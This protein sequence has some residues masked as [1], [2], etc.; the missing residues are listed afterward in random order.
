METVAGMPGLK[1]I[2]RHI[3][4]QTLAAIDIPATMQDKLERSGSRIVSDTPGLDVD[5]DL[6]DYHNIFAV[7][8]GKASLSMARG[9]VEL[10]GPGVCRQ[11]IM[12]APGDALGEVP[13]FRAIAAGHPLPDSGSVRAAREILDLLS[14]CDERSLVFFLLSGGGS[15]LMELP[16]D[17]AV[18]LSDVQ[19]LYRLLVHCG[20][21]I[22][23]INAIRKHLS[24]VK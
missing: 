7:A 16:L 4:Q 14:L 18:T 3:F 5:I 23:E 9:L 12:V 6:A 22:E 11:G 21:P 8:V 1:Q 13:G 19:L 24:A 2:A 10:L 17:S 15:S 20:A